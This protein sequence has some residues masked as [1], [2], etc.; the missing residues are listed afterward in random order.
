[1]ND[2]TTTIQ[3]ALPQTIYESLQQFA[4]ASHKTERDLIVEAVQAYLD[5]ERATPSLVGLFADEHDMLEQVAEDAL[6]T[7]E[8]ATL[9]LGEAA[10]G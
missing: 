3:L 2:V 7:R 1:M 10:H 4:Q 8:E 5:Q 9:R 6:H